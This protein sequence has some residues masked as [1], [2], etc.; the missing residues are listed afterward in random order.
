MA[1][2]RGGMAANYFSVLVA[3][4]HVRHVGR[5]LVEQQ[6]EQRHV[7]LPRQLRDNPLGTSLSE[8]RSLVINVAAALQARLNV[9]HP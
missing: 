1:D 7:P 6:L 9:Q 5:R 4:V 2:A 3:L 8:P